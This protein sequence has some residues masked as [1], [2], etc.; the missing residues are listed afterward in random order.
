MQKEP[1]DRGHV[2]GGARPKNRARMPFKHILEA[3]LLPGTLQVLSLVPLIYGIHVDLS[4][5]IWE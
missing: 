1:V 3:K 5:P 4:Y 2:L